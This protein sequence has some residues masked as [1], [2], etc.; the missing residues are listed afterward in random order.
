MRYR[1]YSSILVGLAVVG[2]SIAPL[3]TLAASDDLQRAIDQKAQELEAVTKQLQQTQVNL[4]EEAVR[5]KTL[6]QEI[7]QIDQNV[8]KVQLGIQFSEITIDKLRLEIEETQR[9]IEEKEQRAA[10]KH[11]TVGRLLQEFQERDNESD[12]LSLLKGQSLSESVAQEQQITDLNEGLISEVGQLQ[13]LKQDLADQLTATTQKKQSVEQE[14]A[15]LKARKTI[16]QDQ[17]TERQRLL[18]ETKNREDNYRQLIGD[19]EKKQQEI[20][21]QIADVEDQLRKEYGTTTVP[22]RRPGMFVRPITGA[23]MTQGY[24]KTKDACRLYKKTC[25]HNGVDYGVP[26]GTAVVAAADGTILAVGNNG[27]VQYGRYIVIKHE[28][29]LATLYSHLSRQVVENGQ[30]IKRGQVIGYSGK[31]GYA[32]GAHLHFGVYL[33]STVVLRSI[34]GAGLVPVGYVLNP[35]DYL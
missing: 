27:R 12:L 33:A 1:C 9:L 30:P 3:P 35:L 10:F 32:F 25:F 7:G 13:K 21:D 4:T 28:S 24:G 29:G 2:G 5:G 23:V 26:I 34:A 17:L 19:L 6:K 11:Q 15:N 16:A 22:L 8:K 31:T 14:R 18:A 20:S